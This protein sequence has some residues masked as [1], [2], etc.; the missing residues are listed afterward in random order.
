MSCVLVVLNGDTI[1]VNIGEIGD[2]SLV[3]S[4][5]ERIAKSDSCEIVNFGSQDYRNLS[6]LSKVKFLLYDYNDLEKL[7]NPFSNVVFT[8]ENI[9]TRNYCRRNKN[10]RITIRFSTVLQDLR[11]PLRS[12][13]IVQFFA[14]QN[15]RLYLLYLLI[16]LRNNLFDVFLPSL[17]GSCHG[18]VYLVSHEYTKKVLKGRT[19]KSVVRMHRTNNS[20]LPSEQIVFNRIVW[21]NSAWNFH[22]KKRNAD[23][24]YNEILE[25]KAF[26]QEYGLDFIVK[27][28]PRNSREDY[29]DGINVYDSIKLDK[30]SDLVLSH[31]STMILDLRD[32]GFRSFYFRGNFDQLRWYYSILYEDNGMVIKDTSELKTFII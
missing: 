11:I 13:T 23:L 3:I 12:K 31:M 4:I 21:I 26:C 5:G 1:N 7:L 29:P 6:R 17:E 28:H 30:G 27:L 8:F 24:Q 19:T 10:K 9:I 16:P 25:L 14:P 32:L 22:G 20:I 2:V 15:L 18:V